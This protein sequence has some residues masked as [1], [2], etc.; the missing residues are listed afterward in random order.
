MLIA[1]AGLPG[2]GK[3]TIAQRLARDLP[4]V[5]LD[6][7]IIRAAIFGSE[8]EYSTHQDDFCMRIMLQAAEYI[9][10]K[11]PGKHVILNGRTF[12]H[13]YQI[14]ECRRFAGELGVSFRIIECVCA[15]ETARQRLER[16][17]IEGRHLA[18]N[19]STDLYLSIKAHFEPIEE[20]KLMVDTDNDLE[21]C[22][23]RCLDYVRVWDDG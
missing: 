8:V 11:D 20:P 14:A 15:D 2:T 18:A 10:G 21:Q 4:G 9:L 5:I 17:A 1:M 23:S 13:G 7:D 19:R 6:K 16:D 22:V 12:S 3:S